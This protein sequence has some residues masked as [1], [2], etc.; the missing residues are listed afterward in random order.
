M[1]PAGGK[2]V[3]RFAALVAV[4]VLAI[5][6][7]ASASQQP[8]IET[9]ARGLDIPWDIAFLPSGGALIT[10]RPGGVRLLTEDGDLQ[11]APV[12]IVPTSALGEGG[13]LGIVLDPRFERNDSVYLYYTALSGMRL[14]RWHWTGTRR[15]REAT[16]VDDIAAGTVPDSGRIGFAPDGRLYVPTGAAGQPELAQDPG[17]LNGKLLALSRR[18]YHGSAPVRPRIL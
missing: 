10:E 9:L 6:P 1:P 18:Q 13:L 4:A 5:A 14:E 15:R 2:A 3:A 12:A 17:S 8:R 11:R 16:L 7:S